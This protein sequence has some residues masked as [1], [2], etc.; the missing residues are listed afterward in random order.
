M[1]HLPQL[2]ATD[3][4][5]Q[6]RLFKIEALNLRFSNGAEAQYERIVGSSVAGAV[7]IAAMDEQDRLLFIREYAAGVHRY[8]LVLPKGR[9]E[10]GE[11]GRETALR[12]LR[13]ETGFA[14][15]E[16]NHLNTVCVAPGYTNFETQIWFARGLAKSPLP[17][18]EPESID[19]VP[20]N[21]DQALAA[22]ASGELN[23][24]RS[25]LAVFLVQA[26]LR[27]Q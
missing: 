7:L 21:I 2:L 26:F 3:T 13:E 17:G 9:M 15:A 20:L 10:S 12:E 23:E 5:A 24:A 25:M 11:E 4:I 27:R 22:M 14:A 18:D 16:F 1:R 8:D 6:S 19:L